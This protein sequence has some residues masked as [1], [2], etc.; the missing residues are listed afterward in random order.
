MDRREACTQIWNRDSVVRRYVV[1]C[2]SLIPAAVALAAIGCTPGVPGET[3]RELAAI[4]ADSGLAS[5]GPRHPGHGFPLW[6]ADK[7]GARA[8]ICFPDNA[9]CGAPPAGFDPAQPVRFPSNFPDEFFYWSATASAALDATARVDLVLRSE[10]RR[11]GKE[12]RSRWS[13]YH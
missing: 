3:S 4:T 10:E 6:Y 8:Q 7:T 13:P 1:S 5:V 11:V 2:V 9:L 12:C